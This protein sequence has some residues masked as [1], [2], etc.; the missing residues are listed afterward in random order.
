VQASPSLSLCI[1]DVALA[2]QC[3]VGGVR[4]YFAKTDSGDPYT[5]TTGLA[6]PFVLVYFAVT[7]I[8]RSRGLRRSGRWRAR[9]SRQCGRLREYV[10]R[11]RRRQ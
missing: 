5:F 6:V 1:V 4:V 11:R 3:T 2:A 7:W 9:G 8:R 10:S